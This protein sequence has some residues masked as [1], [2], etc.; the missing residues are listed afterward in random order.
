MKRVLLICAFLLSAGTAFPITFNI[1]LDGVRD[2]D[3]NF[4][5]M[6]T[7][8]LMVIDTAGDGFGSDVRAGHAATVGATFGGADDLIVWRG[9]FSGGG[10]GAFFDA[11]NFTSATATVP[12][13]RAMQFVWLPTLTTSSLQITNGAAYGTYT[14]IDA[15]QFGSNATWTTGAADFAVY[16]LNAFTEN[17]TGLIADNLSFPVRLADGA[18]TASASAVPEPATYVALCGVFGLGLAVVARRHRARS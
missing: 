13:N 16:T 6:S 18:L 17:N 1:G 9:D 10:A 2:A 14:S 4:V 8:A 5:P 3:G 7:L 11:V 12:S 15:T